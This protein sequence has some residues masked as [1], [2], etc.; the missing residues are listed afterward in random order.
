MK[1]YSYLI[2]K[3]ARTLPKIKLKYKIS[4]VKSF[5]KKYT[6]KINF[7]NNLNFQLNIKNIIGLNNL[8]I[9]ELLNNPNIN[10]L[11]PV[12]LKD[13]IHREFSHVKILSFPEYFSLITTK[14]FKIRNLISLIIIQISRKISP[15]IYNYFFCIFK[16]SIFW[17][18]ASNNRSGIVIK[19]GNRLKRLRPICTNIC[20][21]G[22]GSVICHVYNFSNFLICPLFQGSLNSNTGIIL[23][24]YLTK[25]FFLI[26]EKKTREILTSDPQKYNDFI[27]SLKFSVTKSDDKECK[28]LIYLGGKINYGHTIINDSLS[29]KYFSSKD[30]RNKNFLLGNYDF[31]CSKELY[32]K[33]N[34]S[35]KFDP[36]FVLNDFKFKENIYACPNFFVTPNPSFRVSSEILSIISTPYFE[37]QKNKKPKSFYLI[38][39][40][41]IGVRALK[42]IFEVA[43]LISKKLVEFKIENIILDGLTSLPDYSYKNKKI[44]KFNLNPITINPIKDTFEKNNIKTHIIDGLTLLEK[45]KICSKFNIQ[46]GLASYG[47]GM[48]YG[49]YILNIPLAIGGTDAIFNRDI[50]KKWNWIHSKY[51]H[52]NRFSN[53]EI[54]PSYYYDKNGYHINLKNLDQ[55]LNNRLKT[56]CIL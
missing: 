49:I 14:N 19:S 47:A 41:R 3:I 30:Y 31:L 40:E 25:S 54:L 9:D 8:S 7:S 15:E 4:K 53:V 21:I 13:S 45:N 50:I 35:K 1:D 48:H 52:E 27:E 20:D 56:I 44:K 34:S 42:N 37:K 17:E 22:T 10:N 11:L 43:N 32:Y 26:A 55:Y 39:D 51:C 18:E 46:S 24:D 36:F 28:D 5:K 2:K 29:I 6:K 12:H 33:I 38:V 16:P 23:F